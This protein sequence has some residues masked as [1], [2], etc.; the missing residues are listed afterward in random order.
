MPFFRTGDFPVHELDGQ[1][2]DER[3]T[4]AA[5]E[6]QLIAERRPRSS[7]RAGEH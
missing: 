7:A 1:Q 2:E 4:R 3:Q 6:G 5:A